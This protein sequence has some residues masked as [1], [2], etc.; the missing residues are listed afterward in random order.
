[1]NKFI[2]DNLKYHDTIKNCSFIDLINKGKWA[3]GFSGTVN[4]D[5]PDIKIGI[6]KF[7]QT[8]IEDKDEKIAVYFALTGFYSNND[9]VSYSNIE[10]I[11]DLLKIKDYNCL[12]DIAAVFKDY[13][14]KEIVKNIL[15][16]ERYTDYKGIYLDI[17]DK[18]KIIDK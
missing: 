12:I 4:I 3:T 17:N 8:I 18:A 11:Y 9:V 13:Q 5:L 6:S 14:N 7:N 10:S 16:F 1:M 15:T 2:L